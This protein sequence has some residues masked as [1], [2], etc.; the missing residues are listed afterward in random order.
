MEEG[1]VVGHAGA[2]GD[3][4]GGLN[5]LPYGTALDRSVLTGASSLSFPT[6]PPNL[7]TW[8]ESITTDVGEGR[9]TFRH[10]KTE[11]SESEGK[12]P[13]AFALPCQNTEIAQMRNAR[14]LTYAFD[15]VLFCS[16]I[17]M[18]SKRESPKQMLRR[19]IGTPQKSEVSEQQ[20]VLASPARI[21]KSSTSPLLAHVK[22]TQADA[23]ANRTSERVRELMRDGAPSSGR[24]TELG[25]VATV[26]ESATMNGFQ[27]RKVLED[28][29]Y[30]P[31]FPGTPLR[32]AM[33]DPPAERVAPATAARRNI[34]HRRSRDKARATGDSSPYPELVSRRPSRPRSTILIGI[35]RHCRGLW[36]PGL[37]GH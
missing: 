37:E 22:R 29:N 25:E 8:M 12:C 16:S 10:D 34:T 36:A 13:L 18:E 3:L 11:V 5:C 1:G 35:R 15:V 26:N 14:S 33:F 19:A 23:Q 28:P 17:P 31:M 2:L 4:E 20:P 6:C 7:H 32:S 30:I 24:K 27:Q 21:Q 9:W